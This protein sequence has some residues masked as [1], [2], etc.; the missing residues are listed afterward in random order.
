MMYMECFD[1]LFGLIAYLQI[2][3]LIDRDVVKLENSYQ[4]IYILHRYFDHNLRKCDLNVQNNFWFLVL[5]Y[6]Q[7]KSL[8]E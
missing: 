5:L 6:V 1:N 8:K 3:Y 4:N 7:A 2:L